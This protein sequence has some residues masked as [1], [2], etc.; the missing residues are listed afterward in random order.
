M[1]IPPPPRPPADSTARRLRKIENHLQSESA[2]LQKLL[3]AL[4]KAEEARAKVAASQEASLHPL[5][6]LSDGTPVP[7]S[8]VAQNVRLRVDELMKALGQGDHGLPRPSG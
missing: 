2:W 3:F 7:L 6:V 4:G 1:P 8:L 5:V